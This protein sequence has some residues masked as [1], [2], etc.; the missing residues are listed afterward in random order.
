MFV[1]SFLVL[2]SVDITSIIQAVKEQSLLKLKIMVT[3][4]ELMNRLFRY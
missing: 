1:S 2:Y 4:L 3:I